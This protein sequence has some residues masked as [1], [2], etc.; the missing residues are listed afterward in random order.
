MEFVGKDGEEDIQNAVDADW[1]GSSSTDSI[2]RMLATVVYL[3]EA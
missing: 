3:L 1:T 2:N